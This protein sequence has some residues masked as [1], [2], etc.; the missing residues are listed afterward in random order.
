MTTIVEIL[1]W[2]LVWP[3]AALLIDRLVN[4]RTPERRVARLLAWYPRG[5]RERHGDDLA[6]LLEDAIAGGRDD[7]RLTLNVA[8]EGLVER[9]R[10]TSARR[11][12]GGFLT[13]LGW[14]MSSPK[15][16]SR[17]SW[18]SSS[19]CRRPGSSLCTSA[20]T[21]SGWSPAGWLRWGCCSSI[22]GCGCPASPAGGSRASFQR[23]LKRGSVICACREPSRPCAS[24][25]SAG[26]YR[27]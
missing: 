1:A 23:R 14:T 22:A 7:F 10:T 15:G 20:A 24:G 27:S 12:A 6:E 3:L 5:W 2:T 8:R 17:R 9:A 25:R 18:A 21:S 16:S 13:G 4:P 11:I 26:K 19:R